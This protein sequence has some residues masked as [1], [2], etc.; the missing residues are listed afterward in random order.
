[1]GAFLWVL[2]W[3]LQ[4]FNAACAI[5]TKSSC[6]V[7]YDCDTNTGFCRQFRQ[8][9][10]TPAVSSCPL[11]LPGYQCNQSTG[12]CEAA[13][14]QASP[15]DEVDCPSGFECDTNT[16]I[17]RQ[18][19]APS[20]VPACA[21]VVCMT[22][23]E[24]DPATKSCVPIARHPVRTDPCSGV[25]C[26]FGSQC[27]SNT[28]RCTVF[29]TPNQAPAIPI[30][31][32]VN[33]QCSVGH[34]CDTNTGYCRPVR[35][36]GTNGKCS[37]LSC[38][39][40][41]QCDV[42]TG[43]CRI[44]REPAG[45]GASVDKCR[46]ILCA[47]GYYCDGNTGLCRASRQPGA[48]GTR[49]L[50]GDIS[51]CATVRCPDGLACD[52]NTGQCRSFRTS[53]EMTIPI[54]I[55]I[56]S[57]NPSV[58]RNEPVIATSKCGTCAE[59]TRCDE[60]TGICRGF[61]TPLRFAKL[62]ERYALLCQDVTCEPGFV[63]VSGA[64]EPAQGKTACGGTVCDDD[65]YCENAVCQKFKSDEETTTE[66][67]TTSTTTTSTTV[68]TTTKETNA[69][70]TEKP[71]KEKLPES[72][73]QPK[74]DACSKVKCGYGM[75]CD[76]ASGKCL[77]LRAVIESELV[78]LRRS[79]SVVDHCR[80]IVCF[81]GL[82]CDPKS[83]ECLAIRQIEPVNLCLMNRI[84][85][86][87]DSECDG[88]TGKCI[89]R[90]INDG[91]LSGPRSFS[92]A[93]DPCIAM[94]CP[95]HTRCDSATG[96]CVVNAIVPASTTI[97][98]AVSGNQNPVDLCW[99]VNCLSGTTCDANSGI[100]RNLRII[101]KDDQPV[102]CQG[103]TCPA[104]QKCDLTSGN[105]VVFRYVDLCEGIQCDNDHYCLQGN[106][107]F[108]DV[109]CGPEPCPSGTKCDA[110]SGTCKIRELPTT[111]LQGE[112]CQNVT[113][114]GSKGCDPKTGGCKEVTCPAN[115][116]F[117][118]CGS[119]CPFTC[120]HLD[121]CNESC[122]PTCQCDDAYVQIRRTD[123]QCV[124]ASICR[125]TIDPCEEANDCESGDICVDGMCQP[126]TCPPI[127][128]APLSA[129]MTIACK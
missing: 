116:H 77:T 52:S 6:P 121:K 98:K 10:A 119:P 7:G 123:V 107:V 43:L 30:D 96:R 23:Y 91:S 118:Q 117:T 36:P 127:R 71:R 1:M 40:G 49:Q 75:I 114:T 4:F 18:F 46:G 8:P 67:T 68:S 85:C 55:Q 125:R 45:S 112:F 41:Q 76:S 97:Q 13:Y 86:T 22:G 82:Q 27:D 81:E 120:N 47:A 34:Y 20:S 54:P 99:N 115:S 59:G 70:V 5:C 15:C 14:H 69:T 94:V 64:C 122:I 74:D 2:L 26:P 95:T 111:V 29:R 84:Q 100:C 105:C 129:E 9:V 60:N 78:S 31:K 66:A 126:K 19:R 37:G 108:R 87:L 39:A 38:P 57:T 32:C 113:C 101:Q 63:C 109:G 88:A 83:G 93:R 73:G 103:V 50:E 25:T 104:G 48:S 102:K 79:E 12:R 56:S 35:R 80:N 124:L 92:I 51:L 89:P 21:G 106:C 11:C 3:M 90:K 44:F 58:G 17:C 61:R 42:K 65:E 128:K 72:L 24:C 53:Q 28:G 110:K 62:L 33:V 16:G